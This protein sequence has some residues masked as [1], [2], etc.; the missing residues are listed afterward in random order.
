MKIRHHSIFNNLNSDQINWNDLRNDPDEI[1]YFIP[2][3]KSEYIKQASYSQNFTKEIISEIL[4][5]IR[6]FKIKTI[7]SIG[8]G[9]AY[10]EYGLKQKNLSIEISDLDDSIDRIKAFNIFDKVYKLSFNEILPKIQNFKGLILMSRI[11]TE[12]SDNELKEMFNSMAEINIKYI[13]FIPAQ[14]LTFKSFF[15]EMYLRIK[16]L[17]YRKKLV[18]CGY[19]RSKNLFSNM[20]EKHYKSSQTKYSKSFLLELK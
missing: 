7:L 18:F 3:K 20:W 10:L 8:S 13:F 5:I 15:V 1:Q 11:D 17:L 9:R 2:S 6:E 12:L 14:V 19:S 4:T 16:S